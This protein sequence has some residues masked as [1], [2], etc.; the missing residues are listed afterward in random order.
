MIVAGGVVASLAT[1]VS[2]PRL[3][4]GGIVGLAACV[5]LLAIAPGPWALLVIMFAVG[6]FVMPVQAT[7]MTLVQ[8]S[9]GDGTRGRVAGTLN[10]AIQTASIG[11]MAAAGILADIIGIRSVFA[12]G[13]LVALLAAVVAAFLFRGA[14]ASQPAVA[15]RPE[16]SAAA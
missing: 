16:A 8:R 2:V 1:R 5:G 12:L 4:V 13:A 10:A 6:L 7:T 11:S 3:F 14:P 15:A 9:T